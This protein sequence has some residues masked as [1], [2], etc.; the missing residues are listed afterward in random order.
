LW[1]VEW[2]IIN[3][4]FGAAIAIAGTVMSAGIAMLLAVP[5]AF[6]IAALAGLLQVLMGVLRLGQTLT[7]MPYT[8]ISGFMSGIGVIIVILQL[9]PLLGLALRLHGILELLR[10]L[11]QL[12][13]GAVEVVFFGGGIAEGVR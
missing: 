3:E 8:V 1:Y 12:G 9:P 4:E 11:A 2:D 6:G 5:L 10:N 13:Q 7:F